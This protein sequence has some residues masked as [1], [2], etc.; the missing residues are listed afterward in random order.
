LEA[1]L[2]KE[3][4]HSQLT[5]GKYSS[6]VLDHSINELVSFLCIVDNIVT[7]PIDTLKTWKT[8]Q[9]CKYENEKPYPFDFNVVP[10]TWIF[11][12]DSSTFFGLFWL[13]G[14]I[15]SRFMEMDPLDSQEERLKTHVNELVKF[16][17]GFDAYY[18]V[19]GDPFLMKKN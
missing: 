2:N 8:F 11:K 6:W 5:T 16:S 19:G 9:E 13:I 14:D 18:Q 15:C 7:N 17:R 4:F 1:I 10:P 3:G 12:I